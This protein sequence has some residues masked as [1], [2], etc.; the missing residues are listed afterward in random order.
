MNRLR[1]LLLL[2]CL[3]GGYAGAQVIGRPGHG[4]GVVFRSPQGFGFITQKTFEIKFRETGPGAGVDALDPSLCIN[5]TC[6]TPNFRYKLGDC[7][8]DE[9]PA[10]TY[11]ETLP[12]ANTGGTAVTP[13]AGSPLLGSNDDSVDFNAGEVYQASDADVG[14]IAEQDFVIELIFETPNS[15]AMRPIGT[16]NATAGGAGWDIKLE[17][18]GTSLRATLADGTTTVQPTSTSALIVGGWVHVMM[19]V[20]DDENSTNGVR[21]AV[22]GN[23]LTT[24]NSNA[25]TVGDMTASGNHT[26]S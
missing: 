1:W 3:S 9:C 13:N 17:S 18:S 21:F 12:D 14:D 22:N 26:R 20:N 16:F 19:F 7:D 6:V 5:S 8:A 10:W 4:A 23:I 24:S 25:S 15:A 2:L 11:G